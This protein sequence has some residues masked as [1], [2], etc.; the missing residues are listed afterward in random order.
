MSVIQLVLPDFLLITLGWVLHNKL[1]YSGD[2]F[3]HAEKLVYFVLF[4][5]LL[6]RSIIQTPLSP[7]TALLLLQAV[8]GLLA[9]GLVAV[10]LAVPVLRP[11]PRSHASIAQCGYRFNT[12]VGLS[13][14]G[15]LAGAQ[16]QAVMAV[17]VGLSVPFV[18]VAAVHA[19]ARQQ[20]G[21]RILREIVR[22]P[23][24]IA[25]VLALAGNFLHLQLPQV[26]DVTLARLGACALAMGLL[27]VGATLSPKGGS[28][29]MGLMGWV[30][31]VRM[32]AMPVAALAIGWALGL[33]L[34][35]RQMLL[36]FGAL[37]TASSTYVL[38]S[39]MGG[40]GPLT[41]F[42]MSVST[43]A[44]VVTIPFWLMVSPAS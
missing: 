29:S 20:P 4:P 22:N 8:L 13:L 23:L 2:F 5:A 11:D 44:A 41:A 30:V 33:S 31:A 17:L 40:N 32:L 24:I 9:F 12:Y 16:G 28:G 14:A 7:S 27:C 19:L 18:N 34:M 6:F 36:F 37:P 15:S 1:K 35:E 3:Q 43:V 39:R 25:T 10:W 26:L 38:A 21:G 42:T